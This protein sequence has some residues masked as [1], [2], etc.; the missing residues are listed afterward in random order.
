MFINVLIVIV[1][2]IDLAEAVEFDRDRAIA[3]IKNI[4]PQAQIFEVS[5][6]TGQGINSLL[7]YLSHSFQTKHQ[8]NV[9]LHN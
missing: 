1:N 4:A 8:Q 5:A 9:R 2:K 6:K 7:I 3:N